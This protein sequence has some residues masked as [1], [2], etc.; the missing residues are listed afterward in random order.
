MIDKMNIVRLT[1]VPA[2]LL[3]YA[4]VHLWIMDACVGIRLDIES[5]S[6][7]VHVSL[8]Y[9]HTI[10][11]FNCTPCGLP[12][13]QPKLAL[14]CEQTRP[15]KPF[16]MNCNGSFTP[17]LDIFS[18]DF[19]TAIFMDGVL[20]FMGGGLKPKACTEWLPI[21]CPFFSNESYVLK[22]RKFVWRKNWSRF[23]GNLQEGHYEIKVVMVNQDEDQ[24]FCGHCQCDKSAEGPIL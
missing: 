13:L 20:I 22:Q 19:T 1:T 9:M 15:G 7:S 2:L 18:I 6:Q 12:H 24:I 14:N 23:V 4:L 5:P 10:S 17:R 3:C 11:N 16:T 8:P 21:H